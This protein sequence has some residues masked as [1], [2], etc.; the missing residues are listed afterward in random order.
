MPREI[1]RSTRVTRKSRT[2][3]S[4]CVMS[5]EVRR[6]APL[7]RGRR[8]R[9][10]RSRYQ[11][12]QFIDV[13]ISAT[14]NAVVPLQVDRKKVEGKTPEEIND[15]FAD[16]LTSTWTQPLSSSTEGRIEVRESDRLS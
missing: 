11:R 10:D 6:T 4:A 9:A 5:L 15:Y 2:S 16:L 12:Q 7:V 14:I 8:A 13:N 1:E 3:R